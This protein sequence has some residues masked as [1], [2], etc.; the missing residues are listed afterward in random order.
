MLARI[1]EALGPIYSLLYEEKWWPGKDGHRLPTSN[2]ELLSVQTGW[3]ANPLLKA[4][5]LFNWLPTQTKLSI[6][7][8]QAHSELSS[9]LLSEAVV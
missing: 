8:R 3:G 9:C 2:H 5:V 6:W 4:N 1:S 7:E